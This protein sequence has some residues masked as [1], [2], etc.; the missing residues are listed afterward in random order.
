[1]SKKDIF[2]LLDKSSLIILDFVKESDINRDG[3]EGM[4]TV[5]MLSEDSNKE[6]AVECDTG[7]MPVRSM[8]DLMPQADN[9]DNHSI[10]SK[11]RDDFSRNGELDYFFTEDIKGRQGK[12]LDWLGEMLPATTP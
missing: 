6:T 9:N 7:Y 2:T 10:E 8:H 1:M 4:N 5:S 11:C 3:S 12:T